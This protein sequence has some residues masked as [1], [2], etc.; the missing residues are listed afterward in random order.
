[1]QRR[2]AP[3]AADAP[4]AFF[5]FTL[6]L[7]APYALIGER[8]GKDVTLNVQA[9]ALEPAS[10]L[11]RVAPPGLVFQ[12]LRVVPLKDG[13]TSVR[14]IAFTYL[15]VESPLPAGA[16]CSVVSVY[17]D[18]F[19][20]RVV[21]KTRLTALG[22]KPGASPTRLRFTTLPDRAPAAGYVLT[23]RRFPDGLVREAGTTDRDGRITLKPGA[24]DGLTVFRLTAGN[25]EPMVEFPLV[26]GVGETD[27]AIPPFDPKPL[28]VALE[29]RLDSLR[30]AVVDLV[31][32]RARVEARL[33]ARFEGEDWDGAAEALKLF[34]SLPARD[35]FTRQL[36]ALKTDAAAQQAKTKSPSS[37]RPRKP[38]SPTSRPSSTAIS[39]TTSSAPTA[40]P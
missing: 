9:A 13:K 18:P 11:G 12:P 34:E 22:V 26:P 19:T 16:K 29:T 15:Q 7:F 24:A 2:V 5:L 38:S 3:A 30:D 10:E 36:D 14:E 35:G 1:M 31:A 8:F 25:A 17:S 4:R 39:T 37:P 21:Q 20:K 6:D 40:K 27:R 23:M 33:K 28:T 32:V